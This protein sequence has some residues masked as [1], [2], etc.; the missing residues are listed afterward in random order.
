MISLYRAGDSLI[1][2]LPAW[3]K[4]LLLALML[5][6]L[7][8]LPKVPEV[9]LGALVFTYLAFLISRFGSLEFFR[10]TW[11]FKAL[12]VVIAVPQL[13]LVGI[14][15]GIYNT[16]II[17]SGL[18]LA[19]LVTMTTKTSEIVDL[20]KKAT[21]SE[22]FALLIGLSINSLAVVGSIASGIVEAGKARGVRPSTVR[23]LTNLFVV[24]LKQADDYAEALAA[25]GVEV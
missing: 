8:L 17:L 3:L 9:V 19:T 5:S 13:F 22:N 4:L 10:V 16:L 7:A 21:K 6:L 23:Q 12:A 2:R 24:S 18:I 15:P 20:I 11:R 1:H 14:E 25:R